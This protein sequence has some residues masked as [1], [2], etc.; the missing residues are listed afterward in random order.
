MVR[1]VTETNFRKYIK[2]I[3]KTTAIDKCCHGTYLRTY[4]H[5]VN[6]GLFLM[7]FLGRKKKTSF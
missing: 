6:G 7:P 5:H 2:S 4:D 3:R 1:R